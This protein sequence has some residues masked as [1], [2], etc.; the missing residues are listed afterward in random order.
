MRWDDSV[1]ILEY[2]GDRRVR[3]MEIAGVVF[4]LEQ[5]KSLLIAIPLTKLQGR[6][7]RV[8]IM[9]LHYTKQAFM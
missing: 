5:I 1:G 9:R 2:K 4:G 3:G 6:D 7:I 8:D